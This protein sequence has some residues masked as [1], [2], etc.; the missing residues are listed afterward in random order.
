MKKIITLL[1]L[2]SVTLLSLSSCRGG[3]EIEKGS[4]NPLEY[5]TGACEYADTRDTEGRE[6][7]YVEMMFKNYGKVLVLLD[8]TT[9][10]KTVDHFLKFVND[11]FYNGLTIHR[12]QQNFVIQGGDPNGDGLADDGLETVEGEF[13]DNYHYNNIKHKKGVI[14]MARS[15]GYNSATSQFF[16]CNADA[17]SS[18]DGKY[19]SFGYVI[20][21]L[22][23]IDEITADFSKYTSGD[24]GVIPDYDDQPI[25]EYIKVVEYTE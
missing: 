17:T 24:M 8:K 20:K 16:I 12:V 23:I 3:A 2:L 13:L 5:G 14:S 22:S 1:L 21:G 18:L 11:G 19:A 15:T 10:P 7:F 6:I 25:I 9:A 4:G